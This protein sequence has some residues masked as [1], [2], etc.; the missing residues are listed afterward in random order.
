MA[1]VLNPGLGRCAL[2][3][4]TIFFQ[5]SA[6]KVADELC[7]RRRFER[8]L[9]QRH[10]RFTV[11]RDERIKIDKGF[12]AVGHPVGHSGYHHA[13]IRTADEDN[14]ADFLGLDAARDVANVGFE[15]NV[16]VRLMSALADTRMGRRE[17]L[18]PHL[19]QRCRRVMV[20]LAAIPGAMNQNDICHLSAPWI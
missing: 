16:F 7:N 18:V 13:A 6:A 4:L 5:G 8:L 11:T 17:N 2:G 9:L 15:G 19:A 14:V 1:L 3:I 20:A 12:D 10:Q